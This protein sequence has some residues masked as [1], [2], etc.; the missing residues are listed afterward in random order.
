MQK[1]AHYLA[2][3]SLQEWVAVIR[4]A[5]TVNRGGVAWGMDR[6]WYRRRVSSVRSASAALQQP[7]LL[8]VA[9]F[10]PEGLGHLTQHGP[11]IVE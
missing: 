1:N 9:Q 2:V 6:W 11:L 4:A 3:Y 5:F 10:G 7:R 8:F